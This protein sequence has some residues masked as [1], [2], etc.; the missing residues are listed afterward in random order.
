MKFNL[1]YCLI[2]FAVVFIFVIILVLRKSEY[3]EI[4]TVYKLIVSKQSNQTKLEIEKLANSNHAS[5]LSL[6]HSKNNQTEETQNEIE[7][8]NEQFSNRIDMQRVQ[9]ELIRYVKKW[10]S[11]LNLKINKLQAYVNLLNETHRLMVLEQILP[12]LEITKRPLELFKLLNCSNQEY[13]FLNG[14]NRQT[15]SNIIDV[16]LFGYEIILLEMRFYELYDVVDEFILFES[17]I[18]FKKLPKPYFFKENKDRFLKFI[19]KVTLISPFTITWFNSDGSIKNMI[20]INSDDILDAFK[21]IPKLVYNEDDE[22]RFY[23]DDFNLENSYRMIPLNIYQKYVRKFSLSDIF[24]TGDVDEIPDSIIINHFKYCQV[25]DILFPFSV[26][27]TMYMYSFSHL[28][29]HH[30]SAPNDP[31]SFKYPN[32]LTLKDIQNNGN[33]RLQHSTLLPQVC[34]IIKKKVLKLKLDLIS[35]SNKRLVVVI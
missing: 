9:N 22:R 28:F 23:K 13:F 19:D 33:T 29:Q 27:S 6:F 21:V 5:N 20:H 24:I 7:T 4:N 17:N 30:F 8:N 3:N 2:I 14:L 16:V 1:F 31:Y 35:F 15:P 11:Q 25:N 32:I 10:N 26:W 12:P 18:T 34:A